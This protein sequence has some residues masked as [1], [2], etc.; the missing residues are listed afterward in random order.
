MNKY[1]R[2]AIAIIGIVG[3]MSGFGLTLSVDKVQQRYPWN[4]MVDIDYTVEYETG[5]TPLSAEKDSLRMSFVNKAVQPPTTNVAHSLS[6]TP[7]PTAAGTYRVTWDANADGIDFV[8]DSV[9]VTLEALRYSPKYMIVDV[10][11]LNAAGG[12]DVSYM[13]GEPA[14][15]FNKPEYKGDKIVLRLIQPG[16]YMAGDSSAKHGIVITKPFYIGIFEMTQKQYA[17]VMGKNP[18]RYIGDSRPVDSVSYK[19]LRGNPAIIPY[20]WPLHDGVQT[21]GTVLGA[22]CQRTGLSFDLPTEFEWEYCCRAGTTG[23]YNSDQEISKLGRFTDNG[24]SAEKS[25]DVGT[26]SPNNWGLYDMHGNILEWTRDVYCS[27]VLSLN[28]KVDPV[29]SSDLSQTPRIQRGGSFQDASGSCK[30]S[31]RSSRFFGHA[32]E[33]FGLRLSVR[34]R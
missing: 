26:Y 11:T 33:N 6:H 13:E 30:S 7:L 23:D 27:D 21:N 20:D 14:N 34:T 29:G 25:A 1:L 5:E 24:G 17:N 19:D 32:L 9:S 22:L 8:S 31:S 4:G 2:M 10:S 28:Q 18:S 12:Y 16:S 15:G 3:T